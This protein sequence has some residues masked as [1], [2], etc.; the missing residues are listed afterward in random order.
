MWPRVTPNAAG[1]SSFRARRRNPPRD[2]VGRRLH[3]HQEGRR[4]GCPQPRPAPPARGCARSFCPLLGVAGADYVFIARQETGTAPWP[5]LLD[6]MEMALISLRRRF[7]PATAPRAG[8]RSPLSDQGLTS[9]EQ[10]EQ[11]NLLL[12][13]VLCFG[14]FMI[15]NMLR[16]GAPAEGARG[17]SS[18]GARRTPSQQATSPTPT[19]RQREE[20]VT[21]ELAPAQRVAVNA[22]AIEGSISLLGARIDDVLAEELLRNDPGQG[23]ASA[24]PAR[25][26]CL[27]PEGTERAFYATVAWTTP[28]STTDDVVWT[29]T[30]T[31]PLTPD[32]PLKLTYT[33][34]VVKIDRTITIDADYMFTV[35]DVLTNTGTQPDHADPEGAAA[36]APRSTTSSTTP[37][38]SNGAHRGAL[39]VY[40]AEKNQ[41]VNY[42]DLNQ[43]K[44]VSR[45]V[46]G[47]WNSLTTKYWMAAT[48]P[49]QTEE[50][51][52]LGGTMKLNG[53]T[54]FTAG[55][56]LTPYVIQP[57]QS[58]TKT[59]RI[60]AGAKRVSVLE[61][62][63]NEDRHPRLHR[64]GRLELAVLHHQAVL[65]AAEDASRAGSARSAS[66]FLR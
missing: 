9:M 30:S 21:A 1:C 53:E 58:I 34:D 20:V 50:V 45:N 31:G 8:R 2:A 42:H 25:S 12:A 4:L 16:A 64:R 32:N 27:S 18:A 38:Q 7:S 24:P 51:T 23:S 40:G 61:R 19:I 48:I 57:G 54:T 3:H 41:M 39:G 49:E 26:S 52:M 46:T 10:Q 56:S 17:S 65:L 11:R 43:G 62:Y 60:F 28:T 13:L 37:H 63:E 47:G 29:Q 6:D 66:P 55:Y 59:S 15:Y 14:L 5:R 33:T 36:P 35:T 44:A 22:P